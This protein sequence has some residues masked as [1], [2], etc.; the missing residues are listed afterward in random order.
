MLRLRAEL[1]VYPPLDRRRQVPEP[2][3]A[4]VWNRLRRSH[5]AL[6]N[7]PVPPAGEIA[8]VGFVWRKLAALSA[9]T[10]FFL[11][12]SSEAHYVDE[13]GH[14]DDLAA[15]QIIWVEITSGSENFAIWR[16][17]A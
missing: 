10:H 16:L 15:Q 3:H 13:I 4:F 2:E 8:E 12:R 1:L 9:S 6:Q 7:P 17:C 11:R 5:Y 14:R